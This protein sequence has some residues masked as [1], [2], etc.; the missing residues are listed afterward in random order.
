M[1][2]LE[3]SRDYFFRIIQPALSQGFPHIYAQAAA[4]LAG[5]GSECFGYD[6]ALSRDHDWGTACFLWLPESCRDMIPTLSSWLEELY[7]KHPPA[8][9][10]HSSPYGGVTGVM[11]VADFYR[12]LIGSAE[13]PKALTDWLRI[14]EENL[15]MA[16]NGEVFLDNLGHF[17]RVRNELLQH[18]PEDILRKKLAACCMSMAQT[19][20]Y[21][22]GRMA[23]RR[24]WVTLRGILSRFTDAAME[25][26]FLLNR[27][28]KPYYK[29]AYRAMSELPVLGHSFAP[30][31]TELALSPDF[32]PD[33]LLQQSRCI[34][35]I[36]S[37]LRQELQRQGFSRETDD[38][39]VAHGEAIQQSISDPFLRSL[40]AQYGL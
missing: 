3:V 25:A 21:N 4:G 31:L 23:A 39:L 37:L 33:S 38:F 1:T 35:E 15:A 24:D 16:V 26:A 5:N 32:D 22:H 27:R 36:C 6:D 12:S 14:P 17:T 8:Y 7:A 30:L 18:Y 29:W 34:E 20:Q 10:R 2:G 19:G 13:R 11:T 9:P 28:Y 40:P